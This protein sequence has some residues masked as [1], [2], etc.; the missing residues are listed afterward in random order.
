LKTSSELDTDFRARMNLST[1]LLYTATWTLVALTPGPAVMCAMTQSSRHGWRTGLIGIAGIQCGNLIF[2]ACVA[3]GLAAALATATTV[4]ECLR[5]AGAIYLLYLGVRLIAGTLVPRSKTGTIPSSVLSSR[6]A[7]L[8]GMLIQITNPKALLFVSA[9]LP[10]FINPAQLA[11]SQLAV[12]AVVTAAIDAIV[13]GA[14]AWFA[15]RGARTFRR[16]CVAAW[17]ERTLGAAFVFF[18]LRL[19]KDRR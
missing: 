10:Q 3:A 6:G 18:G 7:F 11:L 19:L 13:L 4:F 15:E 1:L 16:T 2:F 17:L 12:L 5:V 8:Q 14:Y 9:L